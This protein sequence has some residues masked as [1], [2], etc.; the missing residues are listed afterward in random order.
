MRAKAL[1]ISVLLFALAGVTQEQ[2]A[3]TVQPHTIHTSAEGKFETAPDTALV[4]FNISAQEATPKQAYDRAQQQ[5]QRLREILRAN[6]VDPSAAELGFFSI[7]PVYDWKQPKR[8]IVGYRVNTDVSLKLKDFTKVGPIVQQ[9]GEQESAENVNLSYILDNMDAAKLRAVEDA[10]RRAQG[11]AAGV[12]KAG[13]RALAELIYAA[14]D[15][16]MPVPIVSAMPMRAMAARADAAEAAP[17]TAEF[18]PHK[19]TVT[20]RVS[21][22][23][24][25]K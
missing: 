8:K 18:T 4:Q 5:A 11:E 19:I 13:G 10:F 6:G 17:P 21:T 22:V 12:A 7:Q 2:P 23:F 16:S 14:V 1:M 3:V 15:T 24:A 25:M 9:V 20:A